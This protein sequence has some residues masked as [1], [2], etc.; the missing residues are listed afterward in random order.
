MFG[1]EAF[2]EGYWKILYPK[3]IPVQRNGYDCGVFCIK[4][5]HYFARNEP[6]DFQQEAMIYYRK[7]MIWEILNKEI[8]WP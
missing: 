5:A 3:D 8:I 6:M 2:S 4:F 7:R 1:R